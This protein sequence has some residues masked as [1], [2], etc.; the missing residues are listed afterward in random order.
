M[1]GAAEQRVKEA[2]GLS[3][4]AAEGRHQTYQAPVW[5]PGPGEC[6]RASGWLPVGPISKVDILVW[7][8][9]PGQRGLVGGEGAGKCTSGA[10]GTTKNRAVLVSILCRIL[11]RSCLPSPCLKEGLQCP[12]GKGSGATTLWGGGESSAF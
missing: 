8:L 4:G 11:S 2:P 10:W 9:R 6:G 12:E 7:S 3:S 1:P 5:P